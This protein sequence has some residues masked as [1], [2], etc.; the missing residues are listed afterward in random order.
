MLSDGDDDDDE[1][2]GKADV[3]LKDILNQKDS[4]SEEESDQEH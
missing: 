4:S 2:E 3:N 1:D